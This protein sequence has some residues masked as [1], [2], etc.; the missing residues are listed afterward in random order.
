VWKTKQEK[1]F[2]LLAKVVCSVGLWNTYMAQRWKPNK[3]W[4]TQQA[5]VYCVSLS[6]LLS[7]TF[8]YINS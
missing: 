8:A 1:W 3:V 6:G 5:M 2:N 7:K 4:K